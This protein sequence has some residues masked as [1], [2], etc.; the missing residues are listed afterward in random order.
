M[1]SWLVRRNLEYVHYGVTIMTAPAEIA[2]VEALMRHIMDQ[3]KIPKVQ[4]ERAVGPILGMFIDRVLS[5]YLGNDLKMVCAEF[6][7]LKQDPGTYQSTNIDWLLY[8]TTNEELVFLELKTA[9][10]IKKEQAD[11]YLSVVQRIA[12]VDLVGNVG[13]ILEN[14]REKRKYEQVLACVAP[15]VRN[16]KRAKL[17]YLVPKWTAGDWRTLLNGKATVL[18]FEDL[19]EIDTEFSQL[20]SII[21]RYLVQLDRCPQGSDSSERE[22]NRHRNF[23]D[24]CS[25]EEVM[26]KC[27]EAPEAIRVG[28]DGGIRKL[29]TTSLGELKTRRSFKWD[30]AENGTGVKDDRNWISGQTFLEI[31]AAIK[32]DQSS[33][34]P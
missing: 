2:F 21:R 26:C 29:A 8:N 15:E 23:E 12:T 11:I 3:V 18:S 7:L 31:V 32:R 22:S 9:G 13:L 1:L 33:P 34:R 10:A 24:A 14:S 30:Y 5:K 19:P 25:F 16:C 4:V 6:P 28:F 17:I 20:W 27:Q